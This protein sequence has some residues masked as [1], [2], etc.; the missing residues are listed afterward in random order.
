MTQLAIG[1]T[2]EVFFDGECPLCTREI[3]MLRRHDKNSRVAF[4][5]NAAPGFDPAPLGKTMDELMGHIHGRMGDGAFIEGVEVFRQLYAAVGFAPVVALTR[6]P[7]VS[8]ALDFGYR[9]FAKNRL[10]WTG[11]CEPNGACRVPQA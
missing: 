10:K 3:D 7:G 8:H 6:V 2:V 9:V 4:T 11:R 5:D 1:K